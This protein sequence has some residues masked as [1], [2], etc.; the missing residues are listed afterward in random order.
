MQEQNSKTLLNQSTSIVTISAPG[1]LI[2]VFLDLD[3]LPEHPSYTGI[4]EV[5]VFSNHDPR[6]LD[7]LDFFIPF[8]LSSLLDALAVAT[9]TPEQIAEITDGQGVDP[10]PFPITFH[11]LP[12]SS[13]EF[14][15]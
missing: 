3:V 9:W 5:R 14:S 1:V 13:S 2:Q 12:F 4:S 6:F 7:D 10:D 11:P 15:R 8:D